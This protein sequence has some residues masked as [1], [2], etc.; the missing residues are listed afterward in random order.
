MFLVLL[1]GVL[2]WRND[3]LLIPHWGSL[4]CGKCFPVAGAGLVEV[5]GSMGVNSLLTSILFCG[6]WWARKLEGRG[7]E[8]T[9]LI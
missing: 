6:G 1:A 9:L 4:C 3:D 8:V 7:G 2:R 5:G